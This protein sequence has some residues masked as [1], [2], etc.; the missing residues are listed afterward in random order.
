M[1][2]R[3]QL[4]NEFGEVSFNKFNEIINSIKNGILVDIGVY[5]GASSKMMINNSVKFNN[6]VYAIDPIPVFSSDNP[7]Y[8][9]IKDDSVLVGS[10]WDKG[11]VDLVF[12]DSVH[13][14]EQ[15]LCELY[16]WWKII[17][18]G[19][20]AVFHD[21]SWKGYVHKKGHSCEG[22][23]TGNSGKG[24]DTFGGIDWETPEIAVEAF[25]NISI[26]S[27]YRDINK[28]EFKLNFSDD[29]IEVYT[30]YADLGMTIVYK[31]AEFDY[32]INV[33]NWDEIFKK[34]EIL[35]SFFKS[36]QEQFKQISI[37]DQVKSFIKK[38]V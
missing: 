30:N 19:G 23:L 11:N 20:Y 33:N 32:R 22:K 34:R 37:L 29:F 26:N 16:Y 17:K 3:A 4:V 9:F 21:T 28:S 10:K 25:F 2:E 36:S 13:A 15:V 5:E 14:K 12:F 27:N 6:I 24:F 38:I 7:N 18:V 8:N 31:K 1:E 35:L